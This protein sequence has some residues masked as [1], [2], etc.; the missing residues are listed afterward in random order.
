MRITDTVIE[1][2]YE[3]KNN[4]V[5]DIWIY[6]ED[7]DEEDSN[8]A[9]GSNSR[10]RIGR[11]DRM[12]IVLRRMKSPPDDPIIIGDRVSAAY[13]RLGPQET[14]AGVFSVVLPIAMGPSD[15]WS[16]GPLIRGVEEVSQLVFE[17]GYFTDEDLRSTESPGGHQHVLFRDSGTRALVS[18][19]PGR[20][21]WARERAVRVAVDGLSIGLKGLFQP[22]K[23]L[24]Y[25]TPPR[26]ILTDLQRVFIENKGILPSE[27]FHRAE[28]LFRFDPNWF[29]DSTR[30]IADVY[31]RLAEG[32]LDPADLMQELDGILSAPERTKLIENLRHKQALANAPDGPR[33]TTLQ[34]LRGLFSSFTL[35]AEQFL[36]AQQLFAIDGHLFNEAARRIADI[37]G[38]VA[39]GK[40]DSA[41][42]PR[43]LDEVL[44]QN[45]RERLLQELRKKQAEK[46][47]QGVRH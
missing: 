39:S 43:R 25:Y 16:L 36:Y 42:L 4:D 9:R 6:A 3:V 7:P 26:P 11:S 32:R 15:Q 47:T 10:V 20:G 37:Y 40:L 13:A 27:E 30:R 24:Y 41:G 8:G 46:G 44:S 12:V 45:D 19:Y 38:Q 28:R 34:H 18:D 21:I 2:R 33:L 23:G 31:V 35:D 5:G 22:E 1:L 17:L 14:R 29:D